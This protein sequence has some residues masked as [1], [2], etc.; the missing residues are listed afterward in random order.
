M[1][2]KNLYEVK[3]DDLSR[4]SVDDDNGLYW[5]KKIIVSK[6]K[7]DLPL[8]AKIA[9]TTLG[10]LVSISV[11]AQGFVSCMAYFNS[12]K[13]KTFYGT[14]IVSPVGPSAYFPVFPSG[15]LLPGSSGWIGQPPPQ[16]VGPLL[17]ELAPQP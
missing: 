1:P 14:A 6:Q 9:S 3:F 8:W 17:P 5:D 7:I 2:P 16:A 15:P 10:V 13:Q 11:I 4:F 12:P